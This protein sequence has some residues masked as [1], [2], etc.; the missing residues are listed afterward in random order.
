MKLTEQ[1]SVEYNGMK[2]WSNT[3]NEE[4]GALDALR[5]A[6]RT[7]AETY[8]NTYFV[9]DQNTKDRHSKRKRERT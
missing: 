9:R 2:L 8:K 4:S 3:S 6:S 5:R 1:K 7:V